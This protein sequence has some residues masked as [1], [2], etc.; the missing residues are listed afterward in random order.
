MPLYLAGIKDLYSGELVGYAMNERMTQSLV[1]Q[2]L[3]RAV[4]NKRPA[5]GLV[6]HSDRGSQYCAHDY[7]KLLRQFGMTVSM[8][9]KGDCWD[10]APMESFWGTLKNEL[11]YHE[12]F[13]TRQRAIQEITEYV[14]VFYNRQ[15]KQARL[16]YL[17]PATFTQQYYKKLL[18][19]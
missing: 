15:R 19:A 12:K 6:L 8:S 3:F 10:N 17:S 14:E 7:Q 2:A 18:A 5:K 16:G 9:R 4:A 13:D 1:A 11:V